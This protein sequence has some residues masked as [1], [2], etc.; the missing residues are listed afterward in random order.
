MLCY[1]I[2]GM[3]AQAVIGVMTV[4]RAC[5]LVTLGRLDCYKEREG[6]LLFLKGISE[7]GSI[8]L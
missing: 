2:G 5:E 7:A 3:R 1:V 6:E 4:Q 8:Q